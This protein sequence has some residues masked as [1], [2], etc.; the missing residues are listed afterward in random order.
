LTEAVNL[1]RTVRQHDARSRSQF[2]T[3]RHGRHVKHLPYAFTEHGAIMAANILNSPQAVQ[4]SV[5][6]SAAARIVYTAET[7][8]RRREYK[9]AAR[10]RL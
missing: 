9:G 1:Q 5:S 10:L 3:L 4:M 6:F 7:E 8:Q 2:V